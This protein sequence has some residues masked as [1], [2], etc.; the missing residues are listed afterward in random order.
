MDTDR[1]RV[2]TKSNERY[3][4]YLAQGELR[5]QQCGACGYTRHPAR[6]I[7]P[8]CLNDTHD[9]VQH[10]GTGRIEALIWYFTNAVTS[11]A[12]G[13][14]A[15]PDVLP[16]NVAIVKLDEGPSLTTTIADVEFGDVAVGARVDS[17]FVEVPAG[18]TS[19][20]FRPVA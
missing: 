1:D 13:R 8:E 18:F 10:D 12:A 9:W 16:Y 2:I 5:F 17:V 7:C 6:E 3:Y 14:W 19:L 20:Q 15:S 4:S 11:A